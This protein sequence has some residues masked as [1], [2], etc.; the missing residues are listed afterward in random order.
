MHQR[1]FPWLLICALF[2]A[3]SLRVHAAPGEF[4]TPGKILVAKVSGKA[5]KTINGAVTNLE[6]E[7]DI[8]Q[9]AKIN[10]VGSDSSVVILF[11]NGATTRLGGDTELV[12]DE[13]LQD[14]FTA[15]IKVKEMDKEPTP[16]RTKLRLNRGELVGDVKKLRLED[17][18]SFTVQTPVGAAGIRGTVFRIVFRPSANGQAFFQ[19]STAS[20]LVQLS[21]PG[22]N[23][24]VTASGT[25]GVQIP[26]GQGVELMVNVTTNA[27]GQM[28]VTVL[29]P[30]PSA[31][32]SVNATT[33]AQL[34]AVAVEIAGAVQ[35]AVFS[36]PSSGAG[37]GAP[38]GSIGS[39]NAGGGPASS[40]TQ[41]TTENAAGTITVTNPQQQNA[42]PSGQLTSQP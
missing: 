27:Q 20:G 13:Y 1:F 9:S 24:T 23:T 34:S 29:P 8:E 22:Q 32:T 15:Q 31:T 33:L 16:S 4:K 12:I 28:V 19:L 17:N 18:A 5:T 7:M 41:F 14:P 38:S 35:N 11:S 40:T 21:Q 42:I 10:T 2:A 3:V 30:L 36:P 25:A 39:S 26:Q 6:K 37:G